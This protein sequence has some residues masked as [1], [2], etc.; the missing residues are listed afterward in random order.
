MNEAYRLHLIMINYT[1]ASLV[2]SR[3]LYLSYVTLE[4]HGLHWACW[5]GSCPQGCV[6]LRESRGWDGEKPH[7]DT[8]DY[9]LDWIHELELN[10]Q[11]KL[12]VIPIFSRDFTQ[13]LVTYVPLN[14][15]KGSFVRPT[16]GKCNLINKN[17]TEQEHL[18]RWK[19]D[20]FDLMQSTFAKTK[21]SNYDSEF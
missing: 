19:L 2:Y 15:R 5:M 3:H 11:N 13:I 4:L 9:C 8:G 18:S 21:I 16:E 10:D 1:K 14:V 20:I 7:Q 17:V 6:V 12:M